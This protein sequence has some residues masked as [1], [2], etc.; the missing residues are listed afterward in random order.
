VALFQEYPVWIWLGLKTVS[1]KV[2]VVPQPGATLE[3]EP[4]NETVKPYN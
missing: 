4:P 2:E 1:P 3:S